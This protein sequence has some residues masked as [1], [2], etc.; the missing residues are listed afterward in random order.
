MGKHT[1]ANTRKL[2]PPRESGNKSTEYLEYGTG[3]ARTSTISFHPPNAIVVACAGKSRD[4]SAQ[5][6]QPVRV[7]V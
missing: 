2:K 7:T 1:C 3:S 6:L 4:L 5:H